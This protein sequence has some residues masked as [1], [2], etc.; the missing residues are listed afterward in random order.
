MAKT[1]ELGGKVNDS[2]I[3]DAFYNIEGVVISAAKAIPE[4]PANPNWVYRLGKADGTLKFYDGIAELRK[5]A[6]LTP[7][8]ARSLGLVAIDNMT[9]TA[10]KEPSYGKKPV[11][12]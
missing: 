9:D 3:D 7:S 2:E 11:G 4:D 5:G 10:K 6:L 1:Y 8:G 12:N